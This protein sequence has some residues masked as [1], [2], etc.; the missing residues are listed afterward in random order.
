[1]IETLDEKIEDARAEVERRERAEDEAQEDL[2]AARRRLKNASERLAALE[3]QRDA[4]ARA[5][6]AARRLALVTEQAGPMRPVGNRVVRTLC[7]LGEI[8]SRYASTMPDG[9]LRGLASADGSRWASNN[10]WMI[11]VDSIEGLAFF[12][13][14]ADHV[15][16]SIA[17]LLVRDDALGVCDSHPART[18]GE[19]FVRLDYATLIE[20]LFPGLTWH[21][22]PGKLEVVQAAVDGTIVAAVRPMRHTS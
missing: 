16:G 12:A 3:D 15:I 5:A 6:E 11:R 1:M 17:P 2:D 18:F 8:P 19:R 22:L 9:L 14:P 20:D 13:S 7:A 10:H 21:A 4:L